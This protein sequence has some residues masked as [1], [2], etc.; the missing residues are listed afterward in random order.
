[1]WKVWWNSFYFLSHLGTLPLYAIHTNQYIT[2]ETFTTVVTFWPDIDDKTTLANVARITIYLVW[3]IFMLRMC[4]SYVLVISVTICLSHQFKN[5][6]SYFHKLNDIFKENLS[7]EQMESK[8][9]EAFK[10]GVKL[11]SHTL[12]WE[13]WRFYKV[14]NFLPWLKLDNLPLST[15]L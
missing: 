12:W 3:W 6:Q 15:D 10:I 11:H 2:G 9:E 7:Q 1:M 13:N 14:R 4:V 8:Y 5:L